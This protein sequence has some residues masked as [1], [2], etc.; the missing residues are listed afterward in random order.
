MESSLKKRRKIMLLFLLGVGLPS[1]VLGYLAFRGIRNERALME[2][3][4]L[5]EHRALSR[6]LSDTIASEITGAE[7][8]LGR[9]LAANDSAGSLD[10]RRALAVLKQQQS[11]V[12]EV[13]YFDSAGTIELPAADFL[14][15]SDRSAAPARD[16]SWPP[17]VAQQWRTAQQQEFQQRRYDEAQTS[18]RRA[19]A[20]VS[21]QALRGEALIAIARVQ[22]KAGELHAAENTCATLISD[23]SDVRT[24][25]GLPVGPTAYLERGSLLLATGDTAAALKAFLALYEGLAEAEW[26]LDRAQFHFFTAHAGDS[27]IATLARSPTGVALDPYGDSLA[28]LKARAAEREERTERLLLFQEAAAEELGTQRV[29]E[30][31]DA[32]L[33]GRRFTLESA[34]QTHLVSLLDRVQGDAATWGVLLDSDVLSDLVRGILEDRLNPAT[35]GWTLKGRDGRTL[36]AGEDPPLGPVTINATFADNF[37]PWLVEF[38]Q[39]PQSA[40]RRLFASSQSIYFY[41][42]LLI[43]SILTFGLV[44]TVRAVTHELELARLKSD[45]VST[46]SH[47]FKS[48]VTAI[49]HMAEMLQAGS[50]PSEERRRRYYDVLVEQSTRLSSLVTNIL[51]LARIDEGKKEFGFEP[52]DVG[53]LV[54]EIAATTEQRVVHE[55]WSVKAHIAGSLPLVR[56][57]R[58]AITQAISNLVDN[59]IQYSAEVKTVDLHVSAGDSH[60]VVAV[61][62][63]GVGI[64]RHEIDKVF[65]RFYRGGDPHTRS[66]KGSGL[67]LTLV[68]EIVEAHSGTVSVESNPGQGS[69]FTIRLPATTEQDDVEDPDSRG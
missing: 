32:H 67:G 61:Q 60:V 55:G 68:K 28:N 53:E 35:S 47:E 17:P 41:L 43:A 46:V 13:F 57:D 15:H 52:V 4:R 3:R 62:D 2:Q 24:T 38:Y 25:V 58:T 14:Y 64:P 31:R 48:P 5:D 26:L 56:A 20:A 49:R 34:G 50:V 33:Q 37:P 12:D 29:A 21:D 66:V 23:Y 54:R 44:L 7:Q 8:A 69:T 63:R 22:R 9:A 65:D 11:L 16:R 39:R 40:Y 19:F 1:L 42:F 51:D 10:V 45:F 6:L 27:I 30:S 59:A 18:Y 36:L